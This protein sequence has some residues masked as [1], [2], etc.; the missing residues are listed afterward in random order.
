MI[1]G[2]HG[3]VKISFE[4]I[5]CSTLPHRSNYTFCLAFSRYLT[6]CRP[7]G[8]AGQL[9]PAEVTILSPRMLT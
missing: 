3:A 6:T 5:R 8:D 9:I 2:V 1:Q 7:D 4:N